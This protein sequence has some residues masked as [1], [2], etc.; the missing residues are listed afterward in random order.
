VPLYD[1]DENINVENNRVNMR[2]DC[3]MHMLDWQRSELEDRLFEERLNRDE[4]SYE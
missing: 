1:G 2:S 3:F 4:E